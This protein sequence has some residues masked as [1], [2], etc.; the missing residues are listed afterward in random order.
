[1][2]TIARWGGSDHL[3]IASLALV[4]FSCIIAVAPSIITFVDKG[5][6]SADVPLILFVSVFLTLAVA[7][8]SPRALKKMSTPLAEGA[9]LL[10]AWGMSGFFIGRPSSAVS[11]VFALGGSL[12]SFRVIAV[13]YRSSLPFGVRDDHVAIKLMTLGIL[14][15]LTLMSL[16]LIENKGFSLPLMSVVVLGSMHVCSIII[17]IGKDKTD[18]KSSRTEQVAE[19]EGD[20]MTE[21]A[22]K[23]TAALY[24]R[25]VEYVVTKGNFKKRDCDIQSITDA[26]ATNRTYVMQAMKSRQTTAQRFIANQRILFIC[27]RVKQCPE[28]GVGQLWQE[29]GFSSYRSFYR[30]F[31]IFMGMS[32][33]E[34][35]LLQNPDA[36]ETKD[37]ARSSAT[38][39]EHPSRT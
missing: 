39:G 14:I 26:L 25:I 4:L 30:T 33:S 28:R 8:S 35:L 15:P 31:K 20:K 3:K 1:M 17:M 27:S 18:D 32:P 34:W 13:S 11:L 36:A 6:A 9:F 37:G 16:L 22:K 10:M 24:D 7:V 21:E 12:V 5:D 2:K 23:N 38:G 29:A 19:K